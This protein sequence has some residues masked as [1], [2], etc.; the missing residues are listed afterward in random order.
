MLQKLHK[1]PHA[2]TRKDCLPSHLD[3]PTKSAI[4]ENI[5]IDSRFSGRVG[6]VVQKLRVFVRF[7]EN[8]VQFQCPH[9][10]S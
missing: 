5:I 10:G 3:S 6:E 2:E 9:G 1:G 7:P 8:L 4:L